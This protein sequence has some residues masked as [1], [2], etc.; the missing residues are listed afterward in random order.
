[1]KKQLYLIM[2]LFGFLANAC[3][4]QPN[5]PSNKALAIPRLHC[6]VEYPAN[7]TIAVSGRDS[8][9]YTFLEPI[10]D[11]T[12]Q[13]STRISLW[14]E[15]MPF[16][17]SAQ[18]YNQGVITLVKLSNPQLHIDPL[19]TESSNGNNFLGYTFGFSDRDSSRFNVYGYTLLRDSFAFN[20]TM[21]CEAGKE[22]QYQD[23]LKQFLHHFTYSAK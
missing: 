18:D 21:T 1:V 3:Q 12:D 7:W 13:F 10:Q 23:T 17:L 4:T 22:S 20:I 6:A 9:Q 2:A 8:N 16:K 19:P 11:S 15:K 14:N 5:T